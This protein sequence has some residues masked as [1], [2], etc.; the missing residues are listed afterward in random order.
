[1]IDFSNET[2]SIQRQKIA[3]GNQQI[4]LIKPCTLGDG[5]TA[6]PVIA[7]E[8]IFD[9]SISWFIPASGSGSRMFQSLHDYL[10]N[11]KLISADL[12]KFILRLEE[13]V[14]HELL[15]EKFKH[16]TLG[17]TENLGELLEHILFEHGLNFSNLPKGMIPFHRSES[18]ISTAFQDQLIQGKRINAKQLSF[19]F[20][21]QKDFQ[22]IIET[23]LKILLSGDNYSLSFSEQRPETDSFVFDENLDLVL[24]HESIPLRKPA[25]HG[26]LLQN[27]NELQ[28]EYILIKNID[29]V[30]HFNKS[31]QSTTLWNNL[32]E[33]AQVVKNQITEIYTNPDMNQLLELN[34]RYQF[35]TEE[36]L[37]S[38]TN[39]EQIKGFLNRPFRVCGMVK[40]SGQPGGG[41]FWIEKNG[42]V[43]KQIVEKAEISLDLE[44]QQ[45]LEQ[46]THFNPVMIVASVMDLTGEKYDLSLYSDEQS[47]FVVNKKHEGKNIKFIE[48]P[49]LWNG[50]MAFWNTIF[51]EIPSET[52]SPVKTILDLLDDAHQE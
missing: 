30:Q 48:K 45:I 23:S 19:H 7:T 25:G 42:V 20:T 50:S 5:I 51:V 40:N 17:D 24:N 39:S 12:E 34:E 22:Q 26:A 1:M 8:K 10:H 14:F 27:L 52:F 9:T 32:I 38:L 6:L 43:S 33:F 35:S 4:R 28:S 16:V 21:I 49:G 3:S 41:P 36:Y 31:N 2:S 18:V 29:N 11:N 13:F 47:Y 37:R 44:Q 46:S 15:H